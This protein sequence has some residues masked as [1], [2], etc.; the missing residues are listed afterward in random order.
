MFTYAS[1]FNADI[2]DWDVSKVTNMINMFKSATA[3]DQC[4]TGEWS[5][6]TASKT[7]MFIG[8]SKIASPTNT[9]DQLKDAIDGWI[10]IPT[11][12]CRHI[13]TWDTSKVTDMSFLFEDIDEDEKED[14][15][16]DISGWNVSKVT[17]M[18]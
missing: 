12:N 13:S 2:S 3:F 5:E 7:N 8:S 17:N 15:N 14:F 1:Q 11:T 4:L 16:A 9:K 10:S 18:E 6:S